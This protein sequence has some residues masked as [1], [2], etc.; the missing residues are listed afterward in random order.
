MIVDF[1]RHTSPRDRVAVVVTEPLTSDETWLP[2]AP[3]EMRV[4]V[5]GAPVVA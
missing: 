4:F 5:D 3:G 1:A 2:F